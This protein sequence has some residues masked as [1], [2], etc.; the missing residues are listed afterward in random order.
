MIR[1]RS[2]GHLLKTNMN[3]TTLRAL[4]AFPDQLEQHYATIPAEFKNWAPESWDGIP[5]EP[6][7]A[8][9]HLCHIRD[10]ELDGYHVRLQR[11]LDE[12]N[13]LLPSLDG[14]ALS[15]EHS[16]ATSDA[17]ESLAAF[18]SAREKTISLIANLTPQQWMRKATFEGYGSVSLSGLVHFL[19]SHDQQHLSGLQWLL[20]KIESE[21]IK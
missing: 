11:T 16:Y 15:I 8:I 13:P 21:R 1:R 19:C 2:E 20:G 10:I 3:E 9:G 5:S 12:E 7:T 6:F 17:A 4:A 14:L 18:R